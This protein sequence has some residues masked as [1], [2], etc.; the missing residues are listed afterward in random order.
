[1]YNSYIEGYDEDN[2]VKNM[3]QA[4]KDQRIR[5]AAKWDYFV[6]SYIFRKMMEDEDF[7]DLDFIENIM[8]WYSTRIKKR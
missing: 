8:E 1:M 3:E 7:R 5:E 2:E 4:I 6:A